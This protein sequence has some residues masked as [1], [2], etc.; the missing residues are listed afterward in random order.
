MRIPPVAQLVSSTPAELNLR[1]VASAG[2][3]EFS[4][5]TIIDPDAVTLKLNSDSARV[6]VPDVPNDESRVPLAKT[7]TNS[8]IIADPLVLDLYTIIELSEST[9]ISRAY[10]LVPVPTDTNPEVAQLVSSTPAAVTFATKFSRGVALI[11]YKSA[12]EP[13]LS[14]LIA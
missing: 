5:P 9:F 4:P 11:V 10:R 1:I 6:R 12:N 8:L 13:S 3:A 2:D 7:L 14:S